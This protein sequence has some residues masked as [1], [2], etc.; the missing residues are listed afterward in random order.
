MIKDNANIETHHM[1]IVIISCI[2][3]L[4]LFKTLRDFFT[5][6]LAVNKKKFLW[7]VAIP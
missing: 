2:F 1:A 6:V 3:Y 5:S 4:L 7:K